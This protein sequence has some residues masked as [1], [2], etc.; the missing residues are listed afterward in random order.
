[1][2]RRGGLKLAQFA[3]IG[4]RAINNHTVSNCL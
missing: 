1:M 4:S 2:M 3:G